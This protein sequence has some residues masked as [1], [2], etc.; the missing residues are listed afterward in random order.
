MAAAG[1]GPAGTRPR[2]ALAAVIDVGSNSVLLLVVEVGADGRARARD[3]DLATTR[4]GTGLRD[5]GRLDAAAAERTQA[6]V[7]A[8]A[9]RARRAGATHVWAFAT[10]AA[11][12]AAD[13][14]SFVR[15]VAEAAGV[16]TEI[17]SGER[18]AT[19]AYAAVAHGLGGGEGSLLVADVGGGTTELVLG[20]GERPVASVSLPLGALALTEA[21]LAG[22]PDRRAALARLAAAAESILRDTPLPAR[23]ASAGAPL[24]ASGGTATALAALDLGLAAYDARRV[25]GH[26]LDAACLAAQVERLATGGTS[27]PGLDPGRAAILPAG[28]IVLA[29]IASA[30]GASAVRVSD[31]GVRHA[32]LRERLRA[33]GV[34]ADFR[35]PSA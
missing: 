11:R 8:A 30:A 33:L 18:E 35:E 31:H 19:L 3:A 7:V 25:H 32:Y 27:L 13:G 24:A 23:A 17:L 6:A 10:A 21:Y 22:A 2:P 4:L 16:E 14:A 5:G 12:Q 9:G 26:V 28:A 34:D 15:R 29:A 1:D 20:E